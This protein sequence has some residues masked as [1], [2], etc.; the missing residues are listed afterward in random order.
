ME[1]RQHERSLGELFGD[2][3]R[4]LSVLV[5]QEIRLARVEMTRSL[6]TVSK[7][8]ALLVVGGVML[9]AAFLA[10]MATVIIAIAHALLWWLSAL[11]VTL[12]VAGISAVLALKGC[13]SIKTAQLAPHETI[14]TIKE[15][16]AW[17]R[18]QTT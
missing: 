7:S 14:Q 10:L 12:V 13:D 5:R 8:A 15:D 9:F 3:T 1:T 17:M 4:Q 18:E 11:I 6:S 2:L 16:A